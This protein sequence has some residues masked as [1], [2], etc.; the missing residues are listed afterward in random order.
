MPDLYHLPTERP[1][2]AHRYVAARRQL[3]EVPSM[4]PWRLLG[5]WRHTG[6]VIGLGVGLS[7]GGG[8]ALATGVFSQRT[9]SDTQLGHIVT[10]THTGTATVELGPAPRG[11]N[12]ISLTLTG[13]SVGTFRFPDNSSTS[14]SPSDLSHADPEGC[15]SSGVLPLRAG[16]HT[17]TI[18]TS[19]NA[20][21]RLRAT[22]VH[23]VI[24]AWK[25]NAHGQ[26]YGVPN[27]H[28]F[29]DLVAVVFDRGRRSGYV[30]S[31]DF[32]CPTAVNGEN[33]AIPVYTS[34]GTTRIGTFIVGPQGPGIRTV[35]VSSLNCP[36]VGSFGG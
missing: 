12:A 29:P 2:P 32:L 6:I 22:Y 27:K 26:T 8:V 34:N 18:T 1:L 4:K 19:A 14:C 9:P 10:A 15:E 3:S 13:L 20:S 21:W 16:Q 5:R 33:F 31:T 17:V 30:K 24:T 28:G 11:A 36:K 23:Q 7:V 25:T 35:P